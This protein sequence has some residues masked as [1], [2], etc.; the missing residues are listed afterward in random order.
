MLSRGRWAMAPAGTAPPTVSG[1]MTRASATRRRAA[2][3]PDRAREPRSTR[4][5]LVGVGKTLAVLA[6][7]AAVW[8]FSWLEEQPWIGRGLLRLLPSAGVQVAAGVGLAVLLLAGVLLGARRRPFPRPLAGTLVGVV[9]TMFC[10]APVLAGR[11]G[12]LEPAAFQLTRP[13]LLTLYGSYVVLAVVLY[14]W[15]VRREARLRPSTGRRRR[16]GRTRAPT[17]PPLPAVPP[18][19]P[20]Q[21]WTGRVLAVALP[22][23]VVAGLIALGR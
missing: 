15:L 4:A 17:T 7:L 13:L 16:R 5:A 23:T 11:S 12:A 10:I 1:D 21:R 8:A 14:Q 6:A 2:V 18:P 19:S 22:V 3:P 9:A 20:R